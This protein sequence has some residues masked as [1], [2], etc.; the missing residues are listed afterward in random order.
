MQNRADDQQRTNGEHRTMG[1]FDGIKYDDV[2]EI[3]SDGRTDYKIESVGKIHGEQVDD[4]DTVREDD[5]VAEGHV[6]GGKDTYSFA[7]G[8]LKGIAFPGEI[9]DYQLYLND[10]RVRPF[11]I[12]MRTLR[13][14]TEANAAP[15]R[16]AVVGGR[17][18]GTGEVSPNSRES[19]DW[20]ADDGTSARGAV[21]PDAADEWYYS[22]SLL[23]PDSNQ[24]T[25][26]YVD[27]KRYEPDGNPPDGVV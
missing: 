8:A 21:V 7:G 10:S 18:I 1:L 27:G 17:I 26:V 14:E 2:I 11:H 16:F 23:W 24:D 15:Y 13:V 9:G 5:G 20:I 19:S 22:G 3:H 12:N 6:N 4:H 25:T